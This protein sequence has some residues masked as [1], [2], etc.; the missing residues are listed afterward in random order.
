M[1]DVPGAMRITAAF[2]ARRGRGE[3]ADPPR[4]AAAAA[5]DVPHV[6]GDDGTL[7]DVPG[8]VAAIE[9]AGHTIGFS[10]RTPGAEVPAELSNAGYLVLRDSATLLI[11]RA[12]CPQR[13][14]L[15][16]RVDPGELVLSMQSIARDAD[17]PTF[18]LGPHDL[19]PLKR[20]IEA[21][22]GRMVV[23][24]TSAGNWLTIGRLP[25]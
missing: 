16:V 21:A 9:R 22:G 25:F 10:D 3:A 2:R 13:V 15:R 6:A 11:R 4:D 7:A 1:G 23:K 17:A 5:P 18:L 14:Q 8:L 20:R 19:R 12:P 24:T